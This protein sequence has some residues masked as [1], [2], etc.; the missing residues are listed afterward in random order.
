MRVP[1]VV[2]AL[3]L[4]AGCSSGHTPQST[5]T[6]NIPHPAGASDVVIQL[7]GYQF[8]GVPDEFVVGPEL[9]VYGDG[10]VYAELPD[11]VKNGVAQFR[12]LQ[13]H[14]DEA[15]I[16]RLL[17][18][19]EELPSDSPVGVA[20]TDNPARPMIV[21]TH[22]WEINDRSIEPFATYLN[23]LQSAVAA[24]ASEPWRPAR[25]IDR[26]YPGFTC[27]VVEQSEVEPWYN[28]PVYPHLLDQYPLG[29]FDC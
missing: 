4:L 16:Q 7:D 11:S 18:R 12:L 28:A 3:V 15:M 25:W 13:G 19:A 10:S 17:S 20:V 24:G 2:C 27:S 22:T 29:Q 5:T 6:S 1:S 26:P 21:G 14:L 23:E 9:V 8:G